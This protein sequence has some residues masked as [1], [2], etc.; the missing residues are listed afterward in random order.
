MERGCKRMGAFWRVLGREVSLLLALLAWSGTVTFGQTHRWTFDDL[1]AGQL[2]DGW[3][4]EA[5]GQDRATAD[6]QVE[7][8]S[9][10]PHGPGVLA[11]EDTNHS[12]NRV[13]NLCWTDQVSFKEGEISV[14]LKAKTGVIDQGGGPIWRVQDRNNYYI[15]RY[16]PLERNV[17]VYYVKDG[18]R[19]MLGYTGRLEA[20]EGW[21]ILKVIHRGDR[22]QVFLDGIMRIMVNGGNYIPVA[23]GVGLW[24]K[25]DAA[26]SFDDFTVAKQH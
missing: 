19:V 12:Q 23:G 22:I 7:K 14:Y 15:A 9:S 20:S 17:S 1:K 26:T 25:A 24:T 2:P 10:A 5:T 6:W 21:H 3:R 13:F 18:Q 11:L 4:I 8:D 16:N